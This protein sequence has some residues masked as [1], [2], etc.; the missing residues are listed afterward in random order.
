MVEILVMIRGEKESRGK[1]DWMFVA[2]ENLEL[3]MRGFATDFKERLGTSLGK[4]RPHEAP[5]PIGQEAQPA[6]DRRAYEA[7]EAMTARQPAGGFFNEKRG[8]KSR[9][10][11][12]RSAAREARCARD[13]IL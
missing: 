8:V 9:S 4:R 10:R 2:I 13:S 3:L 5:T 1:A 11:P 12:A 6:A 7:A